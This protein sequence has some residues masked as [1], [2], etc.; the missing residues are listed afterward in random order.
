M[1]SQLSTYNEVKWRKKTSE[2]D[3]NQ[4]STER[5]YFR[6][7]LLAFMHAFHDEASREHTSYTKRVRA[8]TAEFS[9]TQNCSL[10]SVICCR[11]KTTRRFLNR[12]KF[13]KSFLVETI[14]LL[15][16]NSLI[17]QE[18]NCR[19]CFNRILCIYLRSLKYWMWI[20]KNKSLFTHLWTWIEL[21]QLVGWKR[22]DDSRSNWQ[23]HQLNM[24]KVEA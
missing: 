21:V 22:V 16:A 18:F 24:R 8:S 19:V 23:R 3:K 15:S 10:H 13:L 9:S 20:E 5:A 2:R 6:C 4:F 17:D 1:P 12:S 11:V 14:S 7:K